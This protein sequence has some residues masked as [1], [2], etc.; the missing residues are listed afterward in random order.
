MLEGSDS[1]EGFEILD[2][3]G[4]VKSHTPLKMQIFWGSIVPASRFLPRQKLLANPL[5]RLLLF[6]SKPDSPLLPLPFPMLMVYW[7]PI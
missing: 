7:W 3:N 1:V 6:P 5:Y 2:A 4:M